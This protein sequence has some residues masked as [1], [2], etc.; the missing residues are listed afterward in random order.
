MADFELGDEVARGKT[1][2]LYRVPGSPDLVYLVALR[3]LTKNDNPDETIVFDEKDVFATRTTCAVFELLERHGI[4]T[5]Y[6]GRVADNVFMA[7]LCDLTKLEVI[8][9][10]YAVGSFLKRWPE[11]E[12]DG[13]VPHRFDKPVFE[14]FLKTAGG[15]VTDRNGNVHTVTQANSGTGRRI[16]DP[17]I[18]NPHDDEWDILHPKMP[19][20]VEGRSCIDHLIS[21]GSILQEGV[22]VSMIEGIAVPVF[23]ILEQAFAAAGSYRLIDF[24]LEL[25]VTADGRFVVADVIDNDAWRLRTSD[26]QELS[27]ERFRQGGQKLRRSLLYTASSRISSSSSSRRH[28]SPTGSLDSLQRPLF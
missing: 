16:D 19:V 15:R 11:L 10:R 22:T 14:L 2:V 13:P 25:G 7:Q 4:L 20:G 26:W 23:L 12:V 28:Y 1:K 8:I 17:W 21:S 3:T 24:K 6:E 9:R 18:G 27:K 5:A